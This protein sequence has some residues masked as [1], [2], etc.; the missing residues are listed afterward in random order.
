MQ[1]QSI[2]LI[3]QSIKIFRHFLKVCSP[4]NFNGFLR[5]GLQGTLFQQIF[6]VNLYFLCIFFLFSI[7][8]PIF[9][10]IFTLRHV[11]ILLLFFSLS[12]NY[13]WFAIIQLF[14][15]L[16]SD[17]QRL[18]LGSQAQLHSFD[19]FLVTFQNYLLYNH[20]AGCYH[21]LIPLCLWDWVGLFL[22]LGKT[23]M[24]L[25]TT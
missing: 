5:A 8:F 3:Q 9:F 22:I 17:N 6:S 7:F 19:D 24:N 25:A 21:L 13:L 15:L 23:G 16:S 10:P 11:K 14:L 18:G 12:S 4:T 20:S 1:F 2:S